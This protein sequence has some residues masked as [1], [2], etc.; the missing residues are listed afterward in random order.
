M[1]KRHIFAIASAGAVAPSLASSAGAASPGFCRDY[2]GAALRQVRGAM[3][4][5]ACYSE[6]HGARWSNDWRIHFDWCRGVDRVD[7]ASE[8]EAR[9]ETLEDCA[10]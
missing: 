8:R 2:A 3:S 9:R 5:T 10:R 7:A 6:V 4:H 1:L